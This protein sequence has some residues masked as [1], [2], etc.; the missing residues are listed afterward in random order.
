M[1]ACKIMLLTP[2]FLNSSERI[3]IQ[4]HIEGRT[5]SSPCT[6]H[7][8]SYNSTAVETHCELYYMSLAVDVISASVE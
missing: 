4:S 7:L 8:K 3:F 5:I 2:Y 1:K 6:K